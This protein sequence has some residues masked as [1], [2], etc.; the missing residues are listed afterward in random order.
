MK[1]TQNSS[2]LCILLLN[3]NEFKTWMKETPI[4]NAYGMKTAFFMERAIC[5]KI[6]I[7]TSSLLERN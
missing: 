6:L 4:V 5:I 2:I 3:P 1:W 7:I